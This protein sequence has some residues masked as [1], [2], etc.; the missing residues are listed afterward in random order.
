MN[1]GKKSTCYT[2]GCQLNFSEIDTI[3]RDYTSE[4][5]ECIEFEEKAGISVINT[6]AVTDNAKEI[7]SKRIKEIILSV[8]NIC[9]YN[10]GEFGRKKQ[11]HTFLN[12]VKE[13]DKVEEIHRLKISSA[14]PNLPRDKTIDFVSTSSSFVPHF[15][16][17]LQS[18]SNEMLKKMKSSYLENTCI[19]RFSRIKDIR[20][21]AC[22][23]VDITVGFPN[24]TDALFL[25]T[26]NYIN[27][28]DISYLHVFTHSERPKTT[29]VSLTSV[30]PRKVSPKRS[31]I[32]RGLS[33]KKKRPFYDPRLGG[34]LS[35]LFERENKERYM[36]DC[37]ENYAKIKTPKNSKLVNT[38]HE[39]TLSKIDK[40]R[41]VRL[42][43]TK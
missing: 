2:L 28:L 11:E 37:T 21:N 39:I 18:G 15:Y 8:V 33:A 7:S 3:T 23:G 38:L 4:G 26:Y 30:I 16:I 41:S 9:T 43:L 1:A 5:F 10:K 36:H 6:C 22:I 35:V 12:L 14:R 34:R 42:K 27:D 40:D 24:Q 31:I 29:P 13:L 32:L 25:E 17:P 20:S 19:N